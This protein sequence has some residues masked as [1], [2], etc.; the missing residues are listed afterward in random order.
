MARPRKNEHIKEQLLEV[1]LETL[2]AKGY[3]GTGIKEVLDKLGVPKGSFYHYFKSKEAF[4]AEIIH[5][6]AEDLNQRLLTNAAGGQ[7]TGLNAIKSA[8]SMLVDEYKQGKSGCILGALASEIAETSELCRLAV[9]KEVEN[10][11]RMTALLIEQGQLSGEVRTDLDAAV[12]SRLLWNCWEGG[13]LRVKIEAT[14][15]PVEEVLNVMFDAIL[16]SKRH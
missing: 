1:G 3:H 15:E 5:F 7:K 11:N 9:S 12:L 10:W 13:V 6:Y 14:S 8:F 2:L 16:A 4:A